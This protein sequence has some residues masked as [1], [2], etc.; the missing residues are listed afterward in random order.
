MVLDEAPATPGMVT[1]TATLAAT[2]VVLIA[3][4]VFGGGTR[5][6]FI[7]D[8]VLQIMAIPPLL[9]AIS[10][11]FPSA[12]ARNAF[13]PATIPRSGPE[14]S[15]GLPADL[16]NPNR[17][18]LWAAV[19]C[20]LVCLW[21]L[22]Q[23]IPLPPA[24]WTGLPD[25]EHIARSYELL[26]QPLPWWPISMVPH[27]T[28]TGWLSLLPPAAVFLGTICLGARARQSLAIGLMAIGLLSVFLGLLQVAQGPGSSLRFFDFTN[29]TEAVGFFAN[30]N[31]YAA[32]LYCLMVLAAVWAVEATISTSARNQWMTASLLSVVGAFAVIVVLIGA[33]AMARSRAGVGL[34]MLA[35]AGAFAFAMADRRT[36]STPALFRLMAAS[37][38]LAFVFAMQFALYRVT[39]R[40]GTD[41]LSDWRLIFTRR[42]Y[43]IARE[44]WLFG[45]GIGTFVPVY[46]LHEQPHDLLANTFVNHAHN[47][48]VQLLLEAGAPAAVLMLAAGLW[49]AWRMTQIWR[50]PP[51][52]ISDLEQGLARAATIMLVLIAIHSFVDYP[53][54]TGAMLAVTAFA[55]ALLVPPPEGTEPLTNEE[56]AA[57]RQAKLRRR[58]ADLVTPSPNLSPAAVRSP[59]QAPATFHWPAERDP[60]ALNPGAP[61]PE[62]E[63][64]QAQTSQAAKRPADPS[65]RPDLHWPKEWAQAE[66]ATAPVDEA[67]TKA[68]WLPK[69]KPPGHEP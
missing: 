21:P 2:A 42:T 19:A 43:A 40:F 60:G 17:Q 62:S 39:D 30:R 57:R 3:S 58:T 37:V 41:P 63:T 67:A 66:P 12:R 8:V 51:S 16:P 36:A 69:Q 61:N 68:A 48:I 54:R 23:L 9:L 46:R 53:L 24:L 32:L 56:P 45:S 10:A 18:I 29:A 34:S 65:M 31:H 6:G 11:L 59:G 33:Q 47:D 35:L 25:R 1:Q 26:G 15:M 28:W 52:G 7:G 44:H 55:M 20:G 38:A 14:F 22:L 13:G 64:L 5:L 49:L 27:A 50:Q 4:V